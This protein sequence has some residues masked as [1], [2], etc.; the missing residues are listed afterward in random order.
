MRRVIAIISLTCLTNCATQPLTRPVL[1]QVT[2]DRFITDLRYHTADNFAKMDFYGPIHLDACYVL[3]ETHRA[4]MKLVPELKKR[5]LKIV[6]WDCFRPISVQWKMW[7]LVPDPR[8]VAD[9]HTG[10]NHNRGAAVDITLAHERGTRL[11]MPTAFDSFESMAHG[12][13]VCPS[14]E[15]VR[16]VNRDL[17]KSLMK[18][19]GLEVLPTE[20]WHFQLPDAAKYPVADEF[21]RH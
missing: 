8:Y 3:P 5:R 6:F 1:E 10:S 12:D 16:C 15:R 18:S 17:L 19:V 14:N 21:E 11:E 4:L 9:P 20:W 2:G 7:K 13:Y